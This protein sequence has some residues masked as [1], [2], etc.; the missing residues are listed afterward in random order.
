MTRNRTVV[1]V[2]V[3]ICTL[4][5]IGAAYLYG[6][7]PE[8]VDSFA[9]MTVRGTAPHRIEG[10]NLAITVHHAYSTSELLIRSSPIKKTAESRVTKG[11]WIILDLSYAAVAH[12][13]KITL[14]LQADDHHIDRDNIAGTDK[15]IGQPG[16]ELPATMVFDVPRSTKSLRLLAIIFPSNDFR[17]Q[18]GWMDTQLS[19]EIPPGMIEQR[20]SVALVDH[21]MVP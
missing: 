17:I 2:Q 9:P 18:E 14:Q 16:I 11:Q 8:R 3:T 7:L 12:S 10:R 4:L 6:H 20:P 13:D 21:R 1:A 15:T 5:L 19:I